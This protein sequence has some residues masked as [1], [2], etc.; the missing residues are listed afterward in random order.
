MG[1]TYR[2]VPTQRQFQKD[3]SIT[4]AIRNDDL[5]LKRIDWLLGEYEQVLRA[6]GPDL[7]SARRVTLCDLFLTGNYWIKSY[8]RKNPA[9]KA[10]RYPAVLAAFEA[11]VNE[12]AHLLGCSQPRVGRT[13]EEIYGR[14]MSTGGIS[15]DDLQGQACK[16]D[17]LRREEFRLWFRGGLAY[18][19]RWWE[20][21]I[22]TTPVLAES[23]RAYND[24][25][26]RPNGAG[27]SV[28][29]GGF[30]MTRER[31]VYMARHRVV[32]PFSHAGVFHS[33]YTDGGR[34]MMAGTMLIRAGAILGVRSDSGH[35]KP[36]EQNMAAF[37]QG[38]AMFGVDLERIDLLDYKGNP[39]GKAPAFLKS[40]LS[41]D[42][43]V[44]QQQAEV[45]NRINSDQYRVKNKLPPKSPYLM[46]QPAQPQTA[47][48]ANAGYR[49][50][51]LQPT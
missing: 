2:T 41:W 8:H 51:R 3:S 13:V 44:R 37:L 6:E 11:A 1:I 42:A 25:I 15:T 39:L 29:Y 10:E 34:V 7:A 36:M 5:I 28:G 17:A 14:D 31:E 23:S 47:S 38:L 30:V 4:F 26:I 48:G 46:P 12:L 40:H 19:R 16:L 27:G 50:L 43:F 22:G 9:M 35:Y 21:T 32:G 45:A 18:Q 33:W 24:D 20:T 49:G